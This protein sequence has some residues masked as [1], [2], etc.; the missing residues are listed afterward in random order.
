[1]ILNRLLTGEEE[2]H[3]AVGQSPVDFARGGVEAGDGQAHG[4]LLPLVVVRAFPQEV[5]C[6]HVVRDWEGWNQ[7]TT[8]G[9]TTGY[10]LCRNAGRRNTHL[11]MLCSLTGT[12]IK[13]LKKQHEYTHFILMPLLWVLDD[14]FHHIFVLSHV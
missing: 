14:G 9:I 11:D 5:W 3:V 10:R 7:T 8:G 1:M 12:Q 2:L 13:L 4:L 6:K